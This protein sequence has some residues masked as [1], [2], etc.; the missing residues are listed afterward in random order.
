[1]LRCPGQE[2]GPQ[3]VFEL[4][5]PCGEQVEFWRDDLR[6]RCPR[7]GGKLANPRREL[8]CAT[9]CRHGRA[10]LGSRGRGEPL[11]DDLL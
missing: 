4:A 9:W 11:A 1:M 8:G 2:L 5:C 10:C 3:D 7:C 6:R